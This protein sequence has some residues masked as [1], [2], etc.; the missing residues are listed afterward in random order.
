MMKSLIVSNQGGDSF[1]VFFLI[2]GKAAYVLPKYSDYVYLE[3]CEGDF[4]GHVDMAN[5]KS[6]MKAQ[7]SVKRTVM[8][9]KDDF[10]RHFTTKA[11]DNCDM[12][13]LSMDD[14]EKMKLE[15]PDVFFEMLQDASEKLEDH[16]ER[17][18]D[19]SSKREIEKAKLKSDLNSK[20][21]AVFLSGLHKTML[22]T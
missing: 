8:K 18:I 15:Y 11:I 12:M 20:L 7:K 17:K 21:S 2:K 13:T 1:I 10:V 4:F 6:F 14:L 19:E 9:K 16:I 5:S 3:I 22:K